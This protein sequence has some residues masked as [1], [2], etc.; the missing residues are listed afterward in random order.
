KQIIYLSILN[1]NLDATPLGRQTRLT[2]SR[3]LV[4]LGRRGL[5]VSCSRCSV[6]CSHDRLL[7]L[8]TGRAADTLHL[9]LEVAALVA[10]LIPGREEHEGSGDGGLVGIGVAGADAAAGLAGL[11]REGGRESASLTVP[12]V[13]SASVLTSAATSVSS[14][15]SAATVA[16]GRLACV[17]IRIVRVIVVAG[18]S[19]VPLLFLASGHGER[20]VDRAVVHIEVGR[21]CGVDG[22]L[23]VGGGVRLLGLL[24]AVVLSGSGTVGGRG[25][26][27]GLAVGSRGSGLS[28]SSSN[29]GGGGVDCSSSAVVSVILLPAAGVGVAMATVV[30]ASVGRDDR[31]LSGRGGLGG[32]VLLGGEDCA[33][34][35]KGHEETLHP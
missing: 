11:L 9:A 34:E 33:E 6:G 4:V 23:R 35:G 10:M 30:A 24:V 12:S 15:S 2:H 18:V 5:S 21:E 14:V 3:C 29:R 7:L 22:E 32:G 31:S 25:I 20:G 17:T 26:G 1:T 13:G 28:V 16:T 19:S 27:G 8:T